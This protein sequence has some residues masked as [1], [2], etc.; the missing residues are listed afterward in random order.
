MKNRLF[1]LWNYTVMYTQSF[2]KGF[3]MLYLGM[4]PIAMWAGSTIIVTNYLISFIGE[5]RAL[6]F[7]AK[8][9]ATITFIALAYMTLTCGLG[10]WAWN[11]SVD[12]IDAD[13]K[14]R[15]VKH[16]KLFKVA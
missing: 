16:S 12:K 3:F 10:Y 9:P 15:E 8:R 2:F 1:T 11:T 7:A 4:M 6:A 14:A 13:F 5:D